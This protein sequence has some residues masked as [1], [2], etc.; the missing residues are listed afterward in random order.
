MNGE[1]ICPECGEHFCAPGQEVSL[2]VVFHGCPL[3]FPHCTPPSA[4]MAAKRVGTA[5]KAAPMGCFSAS[6]P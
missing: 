4:R 1:L 3:L 5:K 2:S 6:V